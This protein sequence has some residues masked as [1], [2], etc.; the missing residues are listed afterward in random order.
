M[1]D[2]P[3]PVS[4]IL[5]SCSRALGADDQGLKPDLFLG[6]DE[7]IAWRASLPTA[8]KDRALIGIHPGSA[9]NACNLPS[10]VY[11]Q[12]ADLLL[13][14]T[15]CG[16]IITGTPNES[17]LLSKWPSAILRSER[18]WQTMGKLDLLQL[19]AAI[20]EM[21]VYVC[22]S[23]GP[24]HIA[25]AVSTPTVSPFCPLAPLNATIWGNVGARAIAL[26]PE[27]CPRLS[28]SMACCNFGGQISTRQLATAVRSLLPTET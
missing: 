23:T 5:L 27:K 6:N 10:A 9:G 28:G 19:A 11:A 12:A 14:E 4:E 1:L 8:L 18:V 22:S 21:K 2:N 7:V 24:L 25:S 15:E 16:L 17:M 3:R 20:A 13:R 26:E